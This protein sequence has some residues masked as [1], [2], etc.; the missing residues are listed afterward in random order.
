MNRGEKCTF[1][2]NFVEQIIH[3][4]IGGDITRDDDGDIVL[5]RNRTTIEVKASGQNSSYGFRLSVD[6]IKHY[7]VIS[8]FPFDRSRYVL[9]AYRNGYIHEAGRRRTEFSTSV[10]RD[11]INLYLSRAILWAVV[12]DLSVVSAWVKT[13]KHST[14]SI[15]GHRGMKTVDVKCSEVHA[16][17]NG[18]F[19]KGL[20][21]CGLNPNKYGRLEGNFKVE[22]QPDLFNCYKLHFPLV[23]VL[24]QTELVSF[25]RMMKRRGFSLRVKK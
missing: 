24:P 18:G 4:V 21:A 19:A 8:S 9:V 13:R 7:Q 5:W 11:S 16:L 14:K 25:Q 1:V 2:G 12:V 3:A 17:A 22:I 10:D 23:A 6:Q 15:I 20:Y